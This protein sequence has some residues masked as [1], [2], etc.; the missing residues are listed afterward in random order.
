MNQNQQT[1]TNSD[2]TICKLQL[3]TILRRSNQLKEP[4]KRK[5]GWYVNIT[6]MN[7]FF[8]QVMDLWNTYPSIKS[9][10][11][12]CA[13]YR[14]HNSAIPATYLLFIL[15]II[16][17]EIARVIFLFINQLTPMPF[18]LKMVP[19]FLIT[20]LIHF[21]V[22][23]YV[24]SLKKQAEVKSY[25]DDLAYQRQVWLKMKICAVTTFV[26]VL[27]LAVPVVFAG[28][29]GEPFELIWLVTFILQLYGCV[30]FVEGII[31]K[32]GQI[33]VYN[34]IFCILAAR[35]KDFQEALLS[36]I[37][38][39]VI[40]SVAFLV[41]HDRSVKMNFILKRMLKEQKLLYKKFLQGLQDPVLIIDKEKLLFHNETATHSL[42]STIEQFYQKAKDIVSET[43]GE[44]LE[45]L[46]K[47]RLLN[48]EIS[49]QTFDRGRYIVRPEDGHKKPRTL[50]VSL[51]EAS[52]FSREKTVSL[53][54]RDVTAEILQE[55]E[56]LEEKYRNMMLFSLSHEL[57]TPL[58]ILQIAMKLAKNAV[59]TKE[60]REHYESGKGAWHYLRNY[61]QLIV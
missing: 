47:N 36:K 7:A 13:Y 39:P 6:I 20:N 55:E 26:C 1:S 50:S 49:P 23:Y 30:W 27:M 22:A 34:A 11:E 61:Q 46:V 40:F 43:N 38:I 32:I 59:K 52:F 9:Y 42:G 16:L 58:N 44:T 8:S 3:Q 25:R 19:A 29:C 24:F 21:S 12:R 4:I 15:V 28:E 31:W 33:A 35:H 60:Q 14:K 18:I 17:A 2:V 10:P 45:M 41:A 53:V 54:L 56:R 37:I 57:R 48:S 5:Y 51:I